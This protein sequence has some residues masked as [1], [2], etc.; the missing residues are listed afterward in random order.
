[1]CIHAWSI[2][3]FHDQTYLPAESMSIWKSNLNGSPTTVSWTTKGRIILDKPDHIPAKVGRI[4]DKT[5]KRGALR[6]RWFS[7]IEHMTRCNFL[8]LFLFNASF[9][10]LDRPFLPL[11]F[12]FLDHLNVLASSSSLS[13][14]SRVAARFRGPSVSPFQLYCYQLVYFILF[15]WPIFFGFFFLFSFFFFFCACSWPPEWEP[16]H[17]LVMS[18]LY[19]LFKRG[20]LRDYSI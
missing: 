8:L 17:P 7:S 13:G 1:M 3:P 18:E 10:D 16:D 12:F 4:E 14:C 20:A 11:D 19:F 9:G 2:D 6:A 15:C 5:R